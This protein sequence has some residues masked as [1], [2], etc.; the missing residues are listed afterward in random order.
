MTRLC[1]F[2]QASVRFGRDYRITLTNLPQRTKLAPLVLDKFYVNAR[3]KFGGNQTRGISRESITTQL[4][5]L[6][7]FQFVYDPDTSSRRI[8][9]AKYLN[10][11][12]PSDYPSF[13]G[14]GQGSIP[15]KTPRVSSWLVGC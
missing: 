4:G 15:G 1:P 13:E 8:F 3:A 5:A 11:A 6:F 12:R 2:T 14:A 7:C 9:Q 10:L